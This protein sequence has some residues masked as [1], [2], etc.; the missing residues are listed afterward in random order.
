MPACDFET[1]CL[2][3]PVLPSGR[4]TVNP[5]EQ[6]AERRQSHKERIRY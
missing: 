1:W 4:Q 6:R 5:V 3:I 2:D